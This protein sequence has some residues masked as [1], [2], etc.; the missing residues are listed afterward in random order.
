MDEE[1]LRDQEEGQRVQHNDAFAGLGERDDEAPVRAATDPL[2][3]LC[4]PEGEETMGVKLLKRMGWKPGQGIGPMVRRAADFGTGAASREQ[5]EGGQETHLFPPRDTSVVIL[6]EKHDRKGLGYGTSDGGGQSSLPSHASMFEPGSEDA[7]PFISLKPKPAPGPRKKPPILQSGF[8]VG[9]LNDTGSDDE[10]PYEIGPQISYN[11]TIG[12]GGDQKPTKPRPAAVKLN[13][14]AIKPVFRP[15]N[16][17]PTAATTALRPPDLRR[18][19]DGRLPPEGFLVCTPSDATISDLQTL[20]PP[21]IVPGTWEPLPSRILTPNSNPNPS[22]STAPP[23]STSGPAPAPALTPSSRGALLGESPLPGKSIFDYLSASAREHLARASGRSDLPA[24]RGEVPP[25]L[26]AAREAQEAAELAALPQLDVP[27]ARAAL[28]RVM[29]GKG[30][31]SAAQRGGVEK[32]ERF[33]GFL[34]GRV[35]LAGEYTSKAAGL[36]GKEWREEVREFVRA[37]EMFRPLSEGMASRFT[38]GTAG[39]NV[40]SGDGQDGDGTTRSTAAAAAAGGLTST[41][42]SATTERAAGSSSAAGEMGK[43]KDKGDA[44]EQAARLGIYGPLTRRVTAWAPDRVL[45][46][47]FGI[48]PPAVVPESLLLE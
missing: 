4:R 12:G 1:D 37:A 43:G 10:D 33:R 20:F 40:K 14:P 24:A 46:R 31:Y 7:N 28:A 41:A 26:A 30:P 13:A 47:R 2:L 35:G 39:T 48:R 27:T 45:C 23:T 44:A 42:S 25:S 18:C 5:V 38:A 3:D 21:P 36:R 29:M 11:R 34:R 8:G 17:V 9:V 15:K 19:H 16:R 6:E 22:T 32:A